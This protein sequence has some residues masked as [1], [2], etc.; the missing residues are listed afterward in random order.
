LSFE[1]FFKFKTRKEIK[2]FNHYYQFNKNETER[3]L[4]EYLIF[5]G[6]PKVV[7]AKGTKEKEKILEEIYTSYLEKDVKALLGVE[8]DLSYKYLL[9]YLAGE[10]GSL[11]KKSE[12]RRNLGLNIKTLNRYLFC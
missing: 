8:K 5:G 9:R 10:T 6:Y 3:I 4:D 12:I 7:L 1:E 11:V 2:E